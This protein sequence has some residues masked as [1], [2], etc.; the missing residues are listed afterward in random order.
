MGGA[1][2]SG[3][4]L[5]WIHGGQISRGGP[6]RPLQMVAGAGLEPAASSL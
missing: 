6:G 4:W 5:F 1:P 3:R 2:L